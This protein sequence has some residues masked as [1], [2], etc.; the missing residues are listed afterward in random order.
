MKNKEKNLIDDVTVTTEY[1]IEKLLSVNE[2]TYEIEFTL[3]PNTADIVGFSLENTKNEKVEVKFDKQAKQITMDRR[4]SGLTAF[5][6]NF[7]S[8]MTA[9]LTE[10][11]QIHMIVVGLHIIV[12]FP[13]GIKLR[14][15]LLLIRLS[16]W[17]T[18]V[19][20]LL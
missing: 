2:G 8:E 10:R 13:T 18:M 20:S 16:R 14:K 7:A 9:P 5:K 4:S 3:T 1:R 15:I 11:A 19:V 12:I 6:D 17:I